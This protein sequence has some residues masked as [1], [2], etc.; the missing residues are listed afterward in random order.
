MVPYQYS[1]TL[2]LHWVMV[3]GLGLPYISIEVV[4]VGSIHLTFTSPYRTQHKFERRHAY[5]G[6]T[7]WPAARMP[8]GMLPSGHLATR[9]G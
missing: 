7:S 2:Q 6:Y 1:F 9:K 5:F 3:V 8:A 4:S